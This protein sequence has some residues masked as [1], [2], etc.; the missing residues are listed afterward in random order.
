GLSGR[1]FDCLMQLSGFVLIPQGRPCAGMMACDAG[2][3]KEKNT[4]GDLSTPAI[5]P[6]SRVPFRPGA[7]PGG[8]LYQKMRFDALFFRRKIRAAMSGLESPVLV[9]NRL[10]QPV[11]VCG[12]RRALGLL[13]LEHAQVVDT[14]ERSGFSAYDLESWMAV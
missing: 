12:V 7:R 4:G 10:W 13:F 8:D 6:S 2:R 5:F 9:L 14:D 11:H 3:A 1:P